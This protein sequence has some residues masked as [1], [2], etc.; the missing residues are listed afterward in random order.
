MEGNNNH[1][2]ICHFGDPEFVLKINVFV[3]VKCMFL[4]EEDDKLSK[5]FV[6]RQRF[7]V[8]FLN[9]QKYK[10]KITSPFI[11]YDNGCHGFLKQREN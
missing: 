7:A 9:S 2:T 10:D 11:Q 3:Q 4:Q 5:S 1:S 6:F 8:F